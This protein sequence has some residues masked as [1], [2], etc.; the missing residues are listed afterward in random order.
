MNKHLIR[1]ALLA[2]TLAITTGCAWWATTGRLIASTVDEVA[3]G[4]CASYYAERAGLSL[5]DAAK[6]F[7]TTQQALEPWIQAV[8]AA[9]KAAARKAALAGEAACPSV[10]PSAAT[11]L[12]QVA[13]A[14]APMAASPT[15]SAKAPSG[16]PAAK[17]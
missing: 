16:Q 7:C 14:P 8:L 6:A 9:R 13:S 17:R 4:M 1:I 3:R 12:P 2:A 10:V 5:D 11:T 15:P